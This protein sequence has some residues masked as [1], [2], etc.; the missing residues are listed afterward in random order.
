MGA[1]QTAL[2]L[3]DESLGPPPGSANLAGSGQ[4]PGLAASLSFPVCE[5]EVMMSAWL[6]E[7]GEEMPNLGSFNLTLGVCPG[8]AGWS[9]R[10]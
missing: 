3:R 8:P 5:V 9:S 1:V 6:S 10:A 4:S 2:P 7:S